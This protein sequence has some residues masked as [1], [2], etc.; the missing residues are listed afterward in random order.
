[1]VR[2]SPQLAAAPNVLRSIGDI[3]VVEALSRITASRDRRF[4]MVLI[5]AIPGTSADILY[6]CLGNNANP[7]VYSWKA[8]ATG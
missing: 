5:K 1:M 6:M 8:V 3:Q 2:P 4:Q 7:T